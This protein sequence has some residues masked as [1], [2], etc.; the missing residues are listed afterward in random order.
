MGARLL[1]LSSLLPLALLADE[2]ILSYKAASK[3]SKLIN[4][5][6][7]IAPAMQKSGSKKEKIICDIL[8]EESDFKLKKE[9][10]LDYK[11][12]IVE[13]LVKNSAKLRSDGVSRGKIDSATS[14]LTVKPTRVNIELKNGAVIISEI[15]EEK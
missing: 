1:L 13:C 9:S 11:D 6:L 3:N 7:S 2:Y 12:E 8:V 14:V 10:L 5:E 4:E 15:L